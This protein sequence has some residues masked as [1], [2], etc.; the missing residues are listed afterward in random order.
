VIKAAF[1]DLDRTLLSHDTNRVPPSAIASLKALRRRG[2]L[3]FAATGRPRSVLETMPALQEL[4][5]DGAVTLTGQYCYNPEGVIHRAPIPAEDI[6]LLIDYLQENPTPCA[7]I[8]SDRS[9]MNFHSDHVYA[10]H[11]AVFSAPPPVGDLL[12][13]LENEVYQIWLYLDQRFI[14]RIPPLPHIKYTWWHEGGVD[15]IPID[16]GKAVGIR[17]MLAHYG[18]SPEE[19]I[20]FGDGENDVDMFRAVGTA[21]AMGNA[22][23]AAKENAHYITTDVDDD[24]I[25]NALKHFDLL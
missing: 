6:R 8:E 19:A 24:G 11:T 5:F 12:R 13:G 10:V 15:M 9:Y 23:R 4:E 2:I 3:V 22:C 7:F 20:A 16:G 14:H 25:F 1:F 17:K 21:V 18:I